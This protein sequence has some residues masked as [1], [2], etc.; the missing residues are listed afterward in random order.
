[1]KILWF[2]NIKLTETQ[3]SGSGTWIS[4]MNDLLST[5]YP[6]VQIANVTIAKVDTVREEIVRGRSQ[7]VLPKK[8]TA[9]DMDLFVK[10]IDSYHPDIIQ[11]WG[12]EFFWATIPF[13]TICPNVP[14]I[15]DM[16]GFYS[17]VLDVLYGDLTMQEI[18]RCF[19]IKE[20][21]RPSSSLIALSRR[22]HKSVN[23]EE[24]VIR[25]YK[26]ISVQS[27]WVKGNVNLLNPKATIYETRIALRPQ[28]FQAVKWNLNRMEPYTI[29]STASMIEPTKGSFTLLK[30]FRE[31]KRLLPQTKLLL[32]GSIQTGIRKSGYMRLM[33]QFIYLNGLSDSISFLGSL[34]TDDLIKAYLHSNVFVNPS[35]AESYSLILAESTYLGVPTVA[36]YAGAMGELGSSKSL[37][38]FSKYDYRACASKIISILTNRELA[39]KLSIQSITFSEKKHDPKTFA[40][41]QFS[42]Y[43]SVLGQLNK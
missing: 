21:L 31:V 18:I 27:N 36:T 30:A 14:V 13:E 12:T 42:I 8:T 5:Y 32:A 26:I 23:R 35:Y 37:L 16:Q 28:F 7:W 3:M 2:S 33:E 4:G 34:N 1:M 24:E 6:D 22:L 25:K 38:Y 20:F 29:F 39:V 11:I 41:T 17:S 10:I 15:L 9:G 40:E 19:S 43:R